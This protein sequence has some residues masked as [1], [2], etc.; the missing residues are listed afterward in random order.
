MGKY[1]QYAFRTGRVNAA[2]GRP[3]NPFRRSIRTVNAG[4]LL[5]SGTT[6]GDTC[7]FG[8][9]QVNKPATP[10]SNTTFGIGGT[11]NSH[12]SE[13][14][15]IVAGGWDDGQVMSSMY[16]FDIRFKGSDAASKDFI[17]AYKFGA[18]QA[19]ALILT[20]GTVTIDNWKDMRQSRGWAWKRFS[21]TNSGGSVYPSQGRIEVKIRDVLKLA[22]GL[23]TDEIEQSDMLCQIIETDVNSTVVPHLHITVFA[24]DGTAFTAGDIAIDV[25]IFQRV[26]LRRQMGSVEMIEEADIQP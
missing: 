2:G 21:G 8:L 4:N 7:S 26:V 9:T 3:I 12:T 6:A 23:F 22:R 10:E 17:F 11:A 18:S 25:T 5:V 15:E 14:N 1:S 16:R 24:I 20:A 19:A 13:H